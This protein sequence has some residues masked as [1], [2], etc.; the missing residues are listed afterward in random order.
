MSVGLRFLAM[1][2]LVFVFGCAREASFFKVSDIHWKTDSIEFALRQTDTTAGREHP[3]SLDVDCL[4]CN[5]IEPPSEAIVDS[6]GVVHLRLPEANFMLSARLRVQGRGLDTIVVLKQRSKKDA[7]MFYKLQTPLV[8][9]VLITQFSI[10]YSDSTTRQTATHTD[11]GDELNLFG[12]N[13]EVFF[14]HHPLYPKPLYL[15]KSSGVRL[16]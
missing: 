13:H 16:Y 11:K 3:G 9:R 6:L 4:N 15:P 5:I 8:G 14:V 10:L 7:E 2:S 1:F 12:E